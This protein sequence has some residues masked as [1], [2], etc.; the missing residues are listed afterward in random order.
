MP[1]KSNVDKELKI[2]DNVQKPKTVF[3]F[4]YD[5][6]LQCGMG[7]AIKVTEMAK[8]LDDIKIYSSMNRSDGQMRIQVCGSS[9]G[10]ANIYEIDAGSLEKAVK[11]GFKLWKF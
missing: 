10:Q 2:D 8:Q 5:G 1:N 9:T 3:V 6:S 7:Q 11:L 4:K